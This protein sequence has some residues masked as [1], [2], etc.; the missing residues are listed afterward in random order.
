VI[1]AA[2]SA[3]PS[4]AASEARLRAALAASTVPSGV[5]FVLLTL[6]G[7]L[8]LAGA[9]GFVRAR[10]FRTFDLAMSLT[11][12]AVAAVALLTF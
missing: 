4:P 12:G 11:G 9:I 1:G 7:G 5:V 10:T 8:F 2:A 6:G 3:T